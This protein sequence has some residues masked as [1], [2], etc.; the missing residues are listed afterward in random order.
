MQKNRKKPF[1]SFKGFFPLK[2][3]LGSFLGHFPGSDHE[4]AQILHGFV[5]L[6][7]RSYFLVMEG[8]GHF[9]GRLHGGPFHFC[10]ILSATTAFTKSARQSIPIQFTLKNVSD[11]LSIPWSCY[12]RHTAQHFTQVV[13]ESPA[14]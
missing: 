1:T 13:V 6:H 11:F 9:Q 10:S 3:Y 4:S 2:S 8:S 12:S 5:D 14:P 7:G